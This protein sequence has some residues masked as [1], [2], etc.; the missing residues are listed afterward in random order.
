MSYSYYYQR[1]GQLA[2]VTLGTYKIASMV[3]F[4]FGIN[5]VYVPSWVADNIDWIG[6]DGHSV[7]GIAITYG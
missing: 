6:W 4:C 5:L 1:Q 2:I 7:L 3:D